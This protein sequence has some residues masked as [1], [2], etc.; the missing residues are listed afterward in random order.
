ML[1]SPFLITRRPS[2]FRSVLCANLLVLACSGVD[3]T[4]TG[5]SGAAPAQTPGEPVTNSESAEDDPPAPSRWYAVT[6]VVPTGDEY[7]GYL[8]G[9]T[10]L[11]RRSLELVDSVEIGGGGTAHSAGDGQLFIAPFETPTFVRYAVDADGRI[12]E[13]GRISFVN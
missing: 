9:T 13:S 12:S 6:T 3:R 10:T 5:G 1:A 4:Q 7:S 2:R 11:E 8:L